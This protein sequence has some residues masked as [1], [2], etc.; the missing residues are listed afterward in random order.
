MLKT[1]G[2]N[3]RRILFA[4]LGGLLLMVAATGAAALLVF[5]RLEAAEAAQRARLLEH[6]TW[7]HRVENGLLLSGS[8]ARDYSA[9]PNGADAPAL[10]ARLAQ[11]EEDSRQAMAK[12][13][14][15][16]EALRGE[17]SAYWQVLDFML[18]MARKRAA[19]G[20]DAYFRRQL[21]ERRESM[22]HVAGEI[23]QSLDSE[24]RRGEAR[25]SALYGRLRWI[26]GAEM[27]LVAGLGLVLSV[28][29]ARRLLQLEGE[30]RSLSAQLERAQEEERR[31]IARELH[32]EIGQAMSRIVLDAGRARNLTESPVVRLQLAAISESAERT[33]EAVRR[34]A[35]SLRPS[36][37][38]DLGLVA[39]LEWQAREVGN[40][41]GLDV[42]VCAEDSAGEMP[43][44]QRT[45]IYRVTQ[46][47]LQNCV[48]HASASTVRV[49]LTQAEKSVTLRVQDNG[50]G[51]RT[52]RT[53]GLGLL[54]MEERVA[55]LGGRMRLRSELGRGT[56]LTV[57]LPL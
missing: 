12:S 37:L 18:E 52:G 29:A 53:R 35:L 13:S 43:D 47:A 20:V 16:E 56:T 33:V 1:M 28:G 34:I 25:L 49:G 8:L 50:K 2:W 45:C 4:S 51:F 41:S 42:E 11:V 6:S 3:M 19:P 21:S 46:E 24:W 48:R 32:D 7:M 17:V 10:L 55:R 40:R 15:I 54:G 9:D 23:G 30:T 39:A 14:G 36:M 22:L 44:L 57:E 31:S 26:L 27:A 38:D 5:Q